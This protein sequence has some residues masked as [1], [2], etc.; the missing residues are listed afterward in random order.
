[1]VDDCLIGLIGGDGN[2]HS[3]DDQL[4]GIDHGLGQEA[5]LAPG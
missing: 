5:V 1:M 2:L 3:K 4:L